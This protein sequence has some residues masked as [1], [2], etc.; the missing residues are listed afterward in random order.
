[1]STCARVWS[2]RYMCGNY[3]NM[4]AKV[5][6]SDT[7]CRCIVRI[8]LEIQSLW[9]PYYT[10]WLISGPGYVLPLHRSCPNIRLKWLQQQVCISFLHRS[11]ILS[12]SCDHIGSG[13][14]EWI[15]ILRPRPPILP[16]ICRPLWSMQRMNTLQNID[17][18]RL[19]N[20]KT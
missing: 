6:T 5:N 20:Q 7:M 18:C 11:L 19:I 12:R 4:V 8:S 10:E 17:M 3:R 9:R 16:N 1:M 14:R 2:Y 15:L 13:T